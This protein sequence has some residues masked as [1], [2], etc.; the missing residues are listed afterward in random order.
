[1]FGGEIKAHLDAAG[2]LT[3]VNGV[4]VPDI[5]V[6]T[7]ARLSAADAAAPAIAE[8]V[9][10]PPTDDS[11][12]AKLALRKGDLRASTKLHVYRMGLV[13]GVARTSQLV[14]EVGV[15]NGSSVRD[16]VYVQAHYGEDRQ[17]LLGPGRT[18]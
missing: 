2:N 15:T 7:S 10:D 1:M 17:P 6:N 9:A 12:G 16:I 3:A 4:A 14:Y 5:A 18:R 11:T 13:R 8:V